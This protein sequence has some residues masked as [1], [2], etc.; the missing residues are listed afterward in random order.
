MRQ[1]NYNVTL[2]RLIANKC[3]EEPIDIFLTDLRRLSHAS[4]IT[5]E[6]VIKRAFV[7][8]LPLDVSKELRNLHQYNNN[9]RSVLIQL[10]TYNNIQYLHDNH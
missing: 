7:T 9:K 4:N 5:E 8:A 10:I 6:I 3:E 2:E 1:H